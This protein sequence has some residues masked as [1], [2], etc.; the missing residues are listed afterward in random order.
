MDPHHVSSLKQLKAQNLDLDEQ[1]I[2]ISKK[3]LVHSKSNR[4]LDN[5]KQK[6]A[7]QA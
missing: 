7:K 4:Q 3:T 5:Q 6:S 2:Q 1:S